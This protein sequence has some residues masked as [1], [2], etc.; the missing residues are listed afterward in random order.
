MT[1][2]DRAAAGQERRAPDEERLTGLEGEL[3]L[4]ASEPLR[5]S[6]CSLTSLRVLPSAVLSWR[7]EASALLEGRLG[8]L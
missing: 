4:S 7:R 2:A 1:E 8:D 3:S 6:F 5:E